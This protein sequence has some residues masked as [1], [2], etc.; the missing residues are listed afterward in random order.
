MIEEFEAERWKIIPKKDMDEDS[1][2]NY[3]ELVFRLK[4][5][6]QQIR[7]I[8]KEDLQQLKKDL[9]DLGKWR[10]FKKLKKD[11]GE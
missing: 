5:D 3:I 10:K 2:E 11:L 6:L 4:N 9:Q 7:P 8:L 1:D